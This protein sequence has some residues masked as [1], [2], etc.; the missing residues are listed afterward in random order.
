MASAFY[1][2]MSIFHTRTGLAKFGESAN[3]TEILKVRQG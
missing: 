3:I 1:L 2:L